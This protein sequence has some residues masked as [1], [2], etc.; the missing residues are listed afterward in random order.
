MT[1]STT[2]TA[3]ETEPR[4]AQSTKAI[5]RI[6]KITIAWRIVCTR[7]SRDAAAVVAD[8]A[9]A[10][11]RIP[12][13]T[14]AAFSYGLVT[15]KRQAGSVVRTTGS[16]YAFV[17]RITNMVERAMAIAVT[18]RATDPQRGIAAVACTTRR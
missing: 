13:T 8:I 14:G 17:G 18:G 1:C 4:T 7:C 3:T 12:V 2:G 16:G 9:R 6:A 11:V 10:A 15:G 5:L